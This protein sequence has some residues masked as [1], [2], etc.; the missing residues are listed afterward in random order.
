MRKVIE[1]AG[2]KATDRTVAEITLPAEPPHMIPLEFRKESGL[3]RED[4]FTI[5]D[6]KRVLGCVGDI[7]TIT[8]AKNAINRALSTESTEAKI[9]RDVRAL[10]DDVKGGIVHT[11]EKLQGGGTLPEV[12]GKSELKLNNPRFFNEPVVGRIMAAARYK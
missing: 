9:L 12:T 5:T 7:T 2:V 3:A 1:R 6:L 10:P 11:I 4:A 8:G